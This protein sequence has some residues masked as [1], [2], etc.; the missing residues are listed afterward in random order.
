MV[1]RRYLRHSTGKQ[2]SG[3]LTG[4]RSSIR[5]EA[6]NSRH[7]QAGSWVPEWNEPGRHPGTSGSLPSVVLCG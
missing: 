4:A 6:R 7:Q 2:G 5:S 1:D 3:T